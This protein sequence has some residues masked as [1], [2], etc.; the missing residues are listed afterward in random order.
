MLKKKNK[1][2]KKNK[3][4]MLNNQQTIFPTLTFVV[5]AHTMGKKY[6]FQKKKK[7][8]ESSHFLRITPPK[9]RF[10]GQEV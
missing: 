4:I 10:L 8:K 2:G 3:N 7:K 5:T 6:F 1:K 9:I